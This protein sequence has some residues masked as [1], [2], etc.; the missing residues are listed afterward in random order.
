MR[1]IT[2]RRSVLSELPLARFLFYSHLWSGL[3]LQDNRWPR[4]SARTLRG[5]VRTLRRSSMAALIRCPNHITRLQYKQKQT[6]VT[7]KREWCPSMNVGT[8]IFDRPRF[9][10]LSY[11]LNTVTK[12]QLTSSETKDKDRVQRTSPKIEIERLFFAAFADVRRQSKPPRCQSAQ[13]LWLCTDY[14]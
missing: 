11:A 14:T 13:T 12:G 4:C 3:T 5:R 8:L 1:E 2:R 6:A 7:L 10:R 9:T